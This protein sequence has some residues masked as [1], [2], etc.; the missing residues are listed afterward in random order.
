MLKNFVLKIQKNCVKK[1]RVKNNP[2]I[3]IIYEGLKDGWQLNG[4]G[5]DWTFS[6][7]GVTNLGH[8]LCHEPEGNNYQFDQN[9]M[10]A[11]SLCRP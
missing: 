8:Y 9:N 4:P 11:N 7:S 10:P 6:Y 5:Y 3:F 1:Y 2:P